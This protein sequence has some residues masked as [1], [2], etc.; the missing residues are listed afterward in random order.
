MIG[1]RLSAQEFDKAV[2][3]L[4]SFI[5]L[6]CVLTGGDGVVGGSVELSRPTSRM[7]YLQKDIFTFRLQWNKSEMVRII[8]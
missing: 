7:L 2:K 6:P 4:N 3:T 5:V 8:L 1:G